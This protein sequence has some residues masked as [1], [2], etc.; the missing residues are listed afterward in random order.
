MRNLEELVNNH[1]ARTSPVDYD[2]INALV[3]KIGFTLSDEYK[4]FLNT[5]GVIVYNSNEVYGL[6]VPGDYYL[7]VFNKYLDL[8]RDASY[9]Q[10]SVPL[11]DVGDGQYYLYNNNTQKVQLWA[12]PHG[13]TVRILDDSLESFLIRLLFKE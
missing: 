6:G 3:T 1:K 10:D 4:D 13:G 11:I 5:F 2:A 12:T 9:P 8:S 7:N